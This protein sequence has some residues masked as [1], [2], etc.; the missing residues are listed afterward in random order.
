MAF[1]LPFKLPSFDRRGQAGRQRAIATEGERRSKG[2]LPLIGNFDI[3]TQF[4]I[5]GTIFLISLLIAI[6]SQSSCKTRPPAGAS[7]TS[8]SPARSPR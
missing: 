8:R 5:L 1:K 4:R 3:E 6:A 2:K 7:P